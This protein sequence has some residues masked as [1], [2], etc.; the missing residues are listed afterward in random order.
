MDES[1]M[2]ELFEDL[3][4][5]ME[6]AEAQ[7]G[8]LLSFLKAKKVVKEKELTPYLEQASTA[9]SLRWTAARA[10]MNRLFEAA[11]KPKQSAETGE[12][13]KKDASAAREKKESQGEARKIG[14]DKAEGEADAGE[15]K[16][17]AMWNPAADESESKQ[18]KTETKSG[19][20]E[21]R[22]PDGS[23]DGAAVKDSSAKQ[24]DAKD[25]VGAKAASEGEQNPPKKNDLRGKSNSSS[26]K[27]DPTTEEAQ[28]SA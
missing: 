15:A 4:Q 6:A 17:A 10:R 24:A 18:K 21:A 13:P 14:H 23:E 2:R 12:K 27:D 11:M 8:A 28:K 19:T 26:A 5:T 16:V 9:A 25:D 3:F 7:S 22:K 20:E 1:L